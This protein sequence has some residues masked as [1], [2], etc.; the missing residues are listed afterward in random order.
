MALRDTVVRT[1]EKAKVF[2]ADE[3]WPDVYA[4]MGETYT[5]DDEGGGSTT[6]TTV[7]SG[8]CYLKPP[9]SQQSSERAYADRIGWASAYI[10]DLPYSTILTPAQDLMV[11]GRHMEVGDVTRGGEYGYKAVA[12]V[13]EPSP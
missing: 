8:V 13:R 1:V 11:N 5:P 3:V 12:V 7:E 2:L 9:S 4:V 6:P 10:V